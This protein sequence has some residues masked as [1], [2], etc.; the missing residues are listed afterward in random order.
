MRLTSGCVA[1]LLASG[2][3]CAGR[4]PAPSATAPATPAASAPSLAEPADAA[5]VPVTGNPYISMSLD[6]S[7]VGRD[8]GRRQV[9]VRFDLAQSWPAMDEIQAPYRR[10]EARQDMDCAA[11]RTRGLRMRI[12]DVTGRVYDRPATDTAWTAFASHPLTETALGPLC[13]T[14]ARVVPR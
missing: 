2:T 1:W 3:A 8:E 14:M 7:R 13:E 6:T 5:W 9:W 4:A 11:R 10:Y 12:V